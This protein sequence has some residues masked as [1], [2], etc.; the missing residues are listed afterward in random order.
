MSTCILISIALVNHSIKRDHWCMGG[1]FDPTAPLHQPL[2]HHHCHIA[3]PRAMMSF[4]TRKIKEF[5]DNK[6]SRVQIQGIST[7]HHLH[8][9]G[10]PPLSCDHF[11]YYDAIE[12]DITVYK[13]NP[14]LFWQCK[15]GDIDPG[16]ITETRMR[17]LYRLAL[18]YL[19]ILPNINPL[20]LVWS[21]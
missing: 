21:I 9:H 10:P 13:K 15:S 20:S 5:L 14:G 12:S 18:T 1:E 8:L 2:H 6:N 3:I 4:F 7:R 11:Y 19:T 16:Q 17:S